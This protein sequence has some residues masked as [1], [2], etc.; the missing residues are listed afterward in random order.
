MK[1]C[2]YRTEPIMSE[3]TK[4]QSQGL[5]PADATFWRNQILQC[6]EEDS[7]MTRYHYSKSRI[8]SLVDRTNDTNHN[9]GKKGEQRFKPGG[10]WFLYD[11]DDEDAPTSRFYKYEVIISYQF[12]RDLTPNPEAILVIDSRSQVTKFNQRYG[13]KTPLG[14]LIN[15]KSVKTD[16]A[17]I[18]FPIYNKS[19]DWDSIWY[20][21]I[22]YP[23]GCVWKV[24]KVQIVES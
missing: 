19:W 4:E 21:T 15:W 13:Q 8:H 20:N 3:I 14:I 5:K 11:A 18:D 23:S 9:Y 16:F 2:S 6:Q 22:D 10:L 17:G 7:A 24:E 12:T 1:F